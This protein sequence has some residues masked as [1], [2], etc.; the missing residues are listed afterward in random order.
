MS[1]RSP[2]MRL[3]SPLAFATAALAL[4][5]CSSRS[6]VPAQ[7]ADAQPGDTQAGTADTCGVSPLRGHIGEL[8]DVNLLQVFEASVPS[9]RVLVMKPDTAADPDTVPER[10]TVK[11]DA[12][13]IIT[14]IGCG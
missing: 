2:M 7:P 5:A 3:L 11:T 8:L 4:T 12:K 6:S 13:S 10:A 1:M 14:S 9:H